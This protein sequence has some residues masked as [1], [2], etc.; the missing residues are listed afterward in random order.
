MYDFATASLTLRGLESPCGN[1]QKSFMRRFFGS[2]QQDL[3]YHK[4]PSVM[5]ARALVPGQL[6]ASVGSSTKRHQHSLFL[7]GCKQR[8]KFAAALLFYNIIAQ[9]NGNKISSPVFCSARLIR[10]PPSLSPFLPVSACFK[11]ILTPIDQT[12]SRMRL[13]LLPET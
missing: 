11:C 2:V 1:H 9:N 5:S 6:Q 10:L 8:A 12:S 13:P 7:R 4:L 3:Q